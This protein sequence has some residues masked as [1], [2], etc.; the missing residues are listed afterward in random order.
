MFVIYILEYCLISRQRRR[1]FYVIVVLCDGGDLSLLKIGT[2]SST[3]KLD[4]SF[5][6]KSSD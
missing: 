3:L 1:A 2:V 5:A 6:L 4:L